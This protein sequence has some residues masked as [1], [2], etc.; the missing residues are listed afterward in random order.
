MYPWI[1]NFTMWGHPMKLRVTDVRDEDWY[2]TVGF[3]R[4]RGGDMVQA[5]K[6]MDGW[7][8][9]LRAM[10]KPGDTVIDCGANVGMT[11]CLFAKHV[12]PAGRVIAIEADSTNVDKISA[13]A[14][15]NGLSNITVMHRAVGQ[16]T[17]MAVLFQVERVVAEA[18]PDHRCEAV[19]TIALDDLFDEF[20]P[21]VVKVDIE[22]QEVNALRGARRLLEAGVKWEIEVHMT[23]GGAH[24][25]EW[26]GLRP[27]ELMDI[28]Q[29]QHGYT[30][31]IDGRELAPGEL[32]HHGAVWA[33]RGE[34]IVHAEKGGE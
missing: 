4:R 17:G 11:S 16:S 21:N 15:L 3:V 6:D 10:I 14:E 22:G 33:H 19:S 12:G 30:V 24:M 28:L 2:S 29:A 13:N 25:T 8:P 9:W 32:P 27:E 18:R 5:A 31:R 7:N 20:K 34:R 23:P 26:F 1:D